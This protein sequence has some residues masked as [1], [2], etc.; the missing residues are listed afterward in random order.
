[1][2]EQTGNYSEMADYFFDHIPT[3][4]GFVDL[5][6]T[7]IALMIYGIIIVL[8]I[9]VTFIKAL[10]FF[11]VAVIASKNLHAKMFHSILLAPMKFFTTNPC[12]RIL[13]RF[14]KDLGAIDELLPRMLLDAIQVSNYCVRSCCER[15]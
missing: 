6:K 10:L 11:K 1:M 15:L 9:I 8:A 2:G 12:G 7:D 5:L 14:S 13:N 3:E 4:N